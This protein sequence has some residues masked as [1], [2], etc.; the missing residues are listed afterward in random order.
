MKKALLICTAACG[1]IATSCTLTVHTVGDNP[2]GTKVARRN[3]WLNSSNIELG[4]SQT[5]GE[6][7]ITKIGSAEHRTMYFLG[8]VRYTTIVTGE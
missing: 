5:A 4:Y 3:A 8:F 1:L 2:V 6:G 7:K